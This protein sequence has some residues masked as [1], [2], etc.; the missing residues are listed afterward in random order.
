MRINGRTLRASDLRERRVLVSLGI[1]PVRGLR[2]PR[3]QNPY[4]VARCIRRLARAQTDDMMF[5][6]HVV[7]A[8]RR[9]DPRPS[10]DLD[11]PTTPIGE[12]IA[13]AAE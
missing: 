12:P 7:A 9:R 2:V 5:L 8:N 11:V 3:T 10:P 4:Q 13:D 1:D 6:R